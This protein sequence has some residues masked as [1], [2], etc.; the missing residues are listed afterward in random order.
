MV[1]NFACKVVFACRQDVFTIVGD[2][3]PDVPK[4][5]IVGDGPKELLK[6][7]AFLR[8][9]R[10]V[11]VFYNIFENTKKISPEQGEMS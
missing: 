3:A 4:I 1:R 11:L 2:G 9:G 8:K 6:M 5:T 7:P 10:P